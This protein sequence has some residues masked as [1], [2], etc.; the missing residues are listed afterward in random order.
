MILKGEVLKKFADKENDN[1]I[2]AP[3]G[4]YEVEKYTYKK[5]EYSHI[6]IA[7]AERYNKIKDLGYVGEGELV[8]QNKR[9]SIE[10]EE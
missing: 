2:Y 10:E 6:F 9:N 3:K 5:T 1:K 4:E 7:D 8:T